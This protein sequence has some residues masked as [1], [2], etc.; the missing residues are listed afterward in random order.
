[1]AGKKRPEVVK[2]KKK[3]KYFFLD[4]KLYRLVRVIYSRDE[5]VALCL[6]DGT[7]RMFAWS[8]VRRHASRGFTIGQVSKIIGRTTRQIHNYIMAGEIEAQGMLYAPTDGRP[9]R[10]IFSEEDIFDIQEIMSNKHIGRPRKDGLIKPK[11]VLGKSDVRVAVKHDMQLYAR[12][13]DG[14]F[15]PVY[16]AEDW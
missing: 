10:R 13:E 1:L 9:V 8:D 12:T 16:L 2:L 4:K 5:A 3:W 6:E 11:N 7:M 15:V 14:E